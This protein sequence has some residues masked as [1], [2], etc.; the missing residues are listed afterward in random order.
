MEPM[1]EK[2]LFERVGGE[3]GLQPIIREF[4]ETM[5]GDAMIGFFFTGV[6][7]EQL[8]R[9][10]LQFTARFLGGRIPY[11]GRSMPKAHARHRIMGGQ[12]DRRRRILEETLERHA[13]PEDIRAAWLSHVDKLRSQITK[14]ASGECRDVEAPEP[15]P[16]P[17]GILS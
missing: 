9:R 12:F 1:A 10:E 4:V 6:D 17:F 16:S 14:D 13:V 5:V 2:T 3:A 7:V 15:P 11:E 8:V